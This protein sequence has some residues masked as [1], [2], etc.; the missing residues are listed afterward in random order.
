VEQKVRQLEDVMS[1]FQLLLDVREQAIGRLDDEA[2]RLSAFQGK[3]KNIVNELRTQMSAMM[4]LV[5]QLAG[6]ERVSL[7]LHEESAQARAENAFRGKPDSARFKP[8][9]GGG[10]TDPG[11]F[12]QDAG[13]RQGGGPGPDYGGQQWG[14]GGGGRA[15][16]QRGGGYG[17]NGGG[18]G[19]RRVYDVNG[20]GNPQ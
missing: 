10:D 8:G 9:G 16:G 19:G 15:P 5:G 14:R 4:K 3:S 7:A 17:R 11:R 20:P 12:R 6:P 2:Q 13:F 1:R 18:R